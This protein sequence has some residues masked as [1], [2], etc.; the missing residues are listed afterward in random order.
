MAT[1]KELAASQEI[2]HQEGLTGQ[3][4]QENPA[5][6]TPSVS[7]STPEEGIMVFVSIALLLC[8]FR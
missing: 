4:G 5:F 8:N 6:T 1:L 2:K 3:Q 7:K